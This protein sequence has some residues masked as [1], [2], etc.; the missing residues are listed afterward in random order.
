MKRE[1]KAATVES[2]QLQ[3]RFA[4]FG[5]TGNYPQTVSEEVVVASDVTSVNAS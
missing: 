3:P 4:F 1:F 2:R 5:I